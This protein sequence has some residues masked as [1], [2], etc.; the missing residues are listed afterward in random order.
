MAMHLAGT[1][2]DRQDSGEQH[3]STSIWLYLPLMMAGIAAAMISGTVGACMTRP[4]G[5]AGAAGPA[6][7][8]EATRA[9]LEGAWACCPPAAAEPRCQVCRGGS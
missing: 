6:A 2:A 7:R 5:A 3:S 8:P 4:A 9:S 1:K